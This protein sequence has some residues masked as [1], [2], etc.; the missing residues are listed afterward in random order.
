MKFAFEA[1]R[2][3][4][5]GLPT[6][7]FAMQTLA[8]SCKASKHGHPPLRL[9]A[10][11]NPTSVRPPPLR[12]QSAQT[13]LARAFGIIWPEQPWFSPSQ[14]PRA[15]PPWANNARSFIRKQTTA[16]TPHPPRESPRIPSSLFRCLCPRAVPESANRGIPPASLR[17]PGTDSR[18][19]DR[20]RFRLRLL[21]R[22]PTSEPRR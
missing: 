7:T 2:L 20:T 21:R 14:H 9:L 4:K 15:S 6:P 19:S 12:R 10:P 1:E 8:R 3:A 16:Q 13:G 22:S 5:P 18:S 17:S 11:N